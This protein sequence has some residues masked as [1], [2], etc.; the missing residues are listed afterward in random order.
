MGI[1][2]RQTI[3]S[4]IYSYA[5]VIVG[6]VTVGILMPHYLTKT[7][8][9]VT[10]QIQYY[11]LLFSSILGFGIPQSLIRLFPH[12]KNSKNGNYGFFALV[13]LITALSAILFSVIFMLYGLEFV[14][15]DILKS[16][17]FASFYQLILP[18]T[19]AYMFLTL[20]E[21]Y[22]TANKESTIAVFLRDFVLRVLILVSIALFIWLPGYNFSQLVHTN[23]YL[24]FVPVI[25]IIIFLFSKKLIHFASKI[26]F[27]SKNTKREFISTSAFNWVNGLSS[28]A[29]VTIDSIMLSKMTDSAD[30]GIYTT[31]TFFAGLML[32]PNRNIGRIASSV[33]A[34]HFKNN[35]L[36]QIESI[37]KKSALTQYA[38]GLFL[39]GN[40]ILAV[41]FIFQILLKNEFNSGIWVLIFLAFTNLFKMGTG[42]KFSIIFTS[43]YYKWS[44]VMFIAFL[45]LIV[46][47]NLWF[48][49][50]YGIVGSALASLIATSIFHLAGLIL[51]KL[52][53]SYWPFTKSFLTSGVACVL[54]FT[55]LFFIPS[56]N[57]PVPVSIVKSLVFST[58]FLLF[59]YRTKSVPEI[60]DLADSVIEKIKDK[61]R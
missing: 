20:F 14:Q 6:F 55:I 35:N 57:F 52:K 33:I 28:V 3:K 26:S 34:D 58:L 31:V 40:L 54:I 38:L 24:Q 9:G 2:G 22:S 41:P 44:T 25:L 19:L 13:T 11:G 61:I 1:I 53:F 27:P 42:L 29:V 18:F 16:P 59:L 45:L 32:I 12:F 47:T 15:K 17:L 51:V 39:L 4:S 46:L 23:V 60:N 50:R 37:Y 56:F 7:E 36:T 8:I 10:R 49:P 43:K 5:G 48:I 30:V 21:S